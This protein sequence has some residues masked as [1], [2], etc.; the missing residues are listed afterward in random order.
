MFYMV[1]PPEN[2]TYQTLA[3]SPVRR[4]E[5]WRY[6]TYA[7]IHAGFTHLLINLILQ[8]AIALPL[9][10]EQGNFSVL[11]VY[12]GGVLSGSL[13]ASCFPDGSLMVGASSGIYSLLMSHVPHIVMNFQSISY[14]C[15]R[16]VFVGF[17][18]ISDIIFSIHHCVINQN[19]EPK[20]HIIAHAAGACCGLLLGFIA[21]E[22]CSSDRATLWKSL[23][24]AAGAVY[25]L[26]IVY[27]IVVSVSN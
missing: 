22:K 23:K 13:A 5:L 9:E 16:I 10:T 4:I 14:R 6:L 18:S 11:L 12:L 17:L 26:F 8:L 20:I 15:Y 27:A 2:L 3:F 19:T 7:L 24:Y 1:Q 21:F 25:G